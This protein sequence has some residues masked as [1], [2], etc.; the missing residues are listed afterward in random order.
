[1]PEELPYKAPLWIII[2]SVLA[3]VILL[4]LIII[5]LWKVR[6]FLCFNTSHVPFVLTSASYSGWSDKQQLNSTA[7]CF[8][9]INKVLVFCFL[10]QP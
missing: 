3:G 2:V 1:M 10:T 8:N 4:G 9:T 5:L 6:N 7:S